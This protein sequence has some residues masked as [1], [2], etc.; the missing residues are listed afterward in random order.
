[1]SSETTTED[2]ISDRWLELDDNLSVPTQTLDEILAERD[3][4]FDED[5][6][7]FEEDESARFGTSLVTNSSVLPITYQLD[8]PIMLNKLDSVSHQ[9]KSVHDKP[10]GG[11]A[12]CLA[13]SE[14]LIAVGTNRGLTILFDRKTERLLHF[15]ND[16]KSKLIFAFS[17][18]LKWQLIFTKTGKNC[19]VYE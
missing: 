8:C 4:G 10:V 6:S 9:L 5:F 18:Y 16:T 14:K 7:A 1:M 12:T 2:D 15:M 19:I 17:N 3:N 13:V 11:K